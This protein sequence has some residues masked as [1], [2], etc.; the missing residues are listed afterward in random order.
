MNSAFANLFLLLQQR[1]QDNVPAI[2]YIDQDF[3]QLNPHI[4]EL[5]VTF[6]CLMIDL[7]YFTFKDLS[8]NVQT[9]MGTI[10]F[11][12]GFSTYSSSEHAA[13]EE[14]RE[15]AL[16]FYDIEWALHKAL[17]GWDAGDYYGHLNR[18]SA[19]TIKRSDSVRVREIRYTVAFEDYST[20]NEQFTAPA[21]VDV[22]PEIVTS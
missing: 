13:P 17:Q 3:G 5:P 21:D 2:T 10:V 22:N 12:L 4:T 18:V 16:Q 15:A 11:K 19:A 1:V 8:E 20:K 14:T 9:A 6:P 7:D